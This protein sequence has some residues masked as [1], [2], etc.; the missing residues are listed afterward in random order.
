VAAVLAVLLAGLGIGALVIYTN[1]AQQRAFAG[2]E[3]V[4]VLRVTDAVPAG[5]KASEMDGKVEE[6]KLPRAALPADVVSSLGQLGSKVATV[7]LVPGEVLVKARFAGSAE[8][9]AGEV[10]V[11]KGLQELT[12][13]LDSSRILGGVLRPGD[14]VGIL[15]S[16]DPPKVENYTTNFAANKVLVLAVTGGVVAGDEAV[17]AGA[18]VMQVRLALDSLAVERVVNA[19]EF[20][21]LW[22]SR[23]GSGAKTGRNVM[24]P[25]E[26][27]K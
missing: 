22:L 12:L 6:V 8:A 7:N 15:A 23:Q 3:T 17:P 13:Q 9:I 4:S 20:G 2:R 5:T 16:Y 24:T 11:P 21:K 1:G 19:A 18:T 27:V 25:A 10:A 26:V 14:F